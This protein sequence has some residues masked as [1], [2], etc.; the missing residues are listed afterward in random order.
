[1]ADS[2]KDLGLLCPQNATVYACPNAD[3]PFVGCCTTDPCEDGSGTC[4]GGHLLAAT[5]DPDALP[6]N[7]SHDCLRGKWYT[8]PDLE[9]PFAGCCSRDACQARCPAEDL[10]AAVLADYDGFIFKMA[11]AETKD[12]ASAESTAARA[13]S[14]D[15]ATHTP[16]SSMSMFS[17]VT[18][19][20]SG[21]TT[22]PGPETTVLVPDPH[23]KDDLSDS[24]EV[25]IGVAAGVIGFL[26]LGCI[27]HRI[28]VHMRKR[29]PGFPHRTDHDPDWRP[30]SSP[31]ELN[32]AIA[33]GTRKCGIGR[34]PGEATRPGS[35]DDKTN[36]AAE[37]KFAG[38]PGPRRVRSADPGLLL[39]KA[40]RV[41]E[42]GYKR[43]QASQHSL[44]LPD[45]RGQ[46]VD[47]SRSAGGTAYPSS[48]QSRPQGWVTG[49]EHAEHH[50]HY[51]DNGDFSVNINS[52]SRG[53]HA[54]DARARPVHSVDELRRHTSPYNPAARSDDQLNRFVS[55]PPAAEVRPAP[56]SEGAETALNLPQYPLRTYEAYTPPAAPTGQ[57]LP[58]GTNNVQSHGEVFEL[59]A[60]PVG[61]IRD[62]RARTTL[63]NVHVLNPDPAKRE[64]I[65]IEAEEV[66]ETTKDKEVNVKDHA[67]ATAESSSADGAT[68]NSTSN[69]TAKKDSVE[70]TPDFPNPSGDTTILCSMAPSDRV[71][72]GPEKD[73]DGQSVSKE[74]PDTDPSAAVMSD[75]EEVPRLD[76]TGGLPSLSP[77]N[78]RPTSTASMSFVMPKGQQAEAADGISDVRSETTR[79]SSLGLSGIT[80]SSTAPDFH[81]TQEQ[82][83]GQPD[84]RHSEVPRTL[85]IPRRQTSELH[86]NKPAD[87]GR[88]ES[89]PP[90]DRRP[91]G[92][93]VPQHSR[94]QQYLG[95]YLATPR[96]EG[97]Y[98]EQRN[99][100][101]G[102]RY[103]TYPAAQFH[104]RPNNNH[105][106]QQSV[107][108]PRADIYQPQSN[109]SPGQ[110][111]PQARQPYSQAHHTRV[112]YPHRANPSR[113]LVQS[114]PGT[115]T[116]P[117]RSAQELGLGPQPQ[118]AYRTFQGALDLNRGND[119]A[120]R[121]VASLP[122]YRPGAHSS[123]GIG[124]YSTAGSQ[125]APSA[126]RSEYSEAWEDDRTYGG[127]S[128]VS[129][130]KNY[131]LGP[132]QY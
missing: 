93:I 31:I 115:A 122:A 24:Q 62:P 89:Q 28:I 23:G 45:V 34:M 114:P 46:L 72:Q 102:G 8:C 91:E 82:R 130:W 97:G 51:S 100:Q 39:G 86:M 38:L 33:P 131:S 95:R 42:Q 94:Q 43:G 29:R 70:K 96:R 50:S 66:K 107:Q 109:H 126:P 14:T 128:E 90:A 78:S 59:E 84:L 41:S 120:R 54:T 106:A 32:S 113:P 3:S 119:I 2:T 104:T 53:S 88:H 87:D 49:N 52:H 47:G 5:F 4:P 111:S 6:S 19:S 16:S 11:G 98:N 75:S 121:D 77:D 76:A 15:E 80:P 116:H 36:N 57:H 37:T 40:S 61:Q 118:P 9:T 117:R 55:Y 27:V 63:G 79:R 108:D 69:T 22:D 17:T 58:G 7:L 125:Y 85:A 25:G 65:V 44:P 67:P 71:P 12:A 48:Q 81:A 110:T 35:W 56:R 99:E 60:E 129:S 1:M 83:P 13:T 26:V 132:Q 68:S 10:R 103:A 123:A 112:Y 30:P 101:H 124:G 20:P 21:T 92:I 127:G 105:A 73:P 74:V 64:S 18:D